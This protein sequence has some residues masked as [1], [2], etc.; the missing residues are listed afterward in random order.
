M[1]E[2]GVQQ[3]G[4]Y[5]KWHHLLLTWQFL[6]GPGPRG[7]LGIGTVTSALRRAAGKHEL[8]LCGTA[9]GLARDPPRCHSIPPTCSSALGRRTQ[10]SP[11]VWREIPGPGRGL[12][13]GNPSPRRHRG[14]RGAAPSPFI[15]CLAWPLALP[16]PGRAA[17]RRG[18]R[19][20]SGTPVPR[21][22]CILGCRRAQRPVY[23]PMETPLCCCFSSQTRSQLGGSQ[24]LRIPHSFHQQLRGAALPGPPC[25]H[26]LAAPSRPLARTGV[27]PPSQPAPQTLHPP[28]GTLRGSNPSRCPAAPA[29]PSTP[30]P[31]QG[32]VLHPTTTGHG[33]GAE[34]SLPTQTR[35]FR[36]ETPPQHVSTAREEVFIPAAAAVARRKS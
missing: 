34:L 35:T 36:V 29:C 28:H 30:E 8:R 6:C 5:C 22:G 25:I 1:Q 18:A 3:P 24:Q 20:G 33:A 21:P 7:Q 32:S 17:S 10:H 15:A 31:A 26:Q 4:T 23:I 13:G 11:V 19:G 16:G 27:L 12:A 14:G 2:R 9:P